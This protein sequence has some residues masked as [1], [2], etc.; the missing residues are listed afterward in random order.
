[1]SYLTGTELNQ[2]Q[3][4]VLIEFLAANPLLPKSAVQSLNKGLNTTKQQIIPAINEVLGSL[5]TLNTT[6]IASLSQQAGIVGDTMADPTLKTRLVAYAPSVIDAIL[7]L[8]DEIA[9]LKAKATDRY[10]DFAQSIVVADAVQTVFPLQYIPCSPIQLIVN[11]V[12][13]TSGFS[14]DKAS[15]SITWLDTVANKGEGGFDIAKG[16]EVGF[17]YDFLYSQNPS[18]VGVVV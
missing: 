8:A 15:N 6:T 3:S 10:D 7:K 9:S 5:K 13:Y 14:Y 17:I 12:T 4:D 1:M 2:H 11:G 18:A 16:Y